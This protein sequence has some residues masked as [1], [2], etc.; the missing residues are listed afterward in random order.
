MDI[1]EVQSQGHFCPSA[2]TV[3]LHEQHGEGKD[4]FSWFLEII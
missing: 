4:M 2:E 3:W 1:L